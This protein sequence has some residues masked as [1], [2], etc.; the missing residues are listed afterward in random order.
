MAS[1]SPSAIGICFL[2][3]STESYQRMLKQLHHDGEKGKS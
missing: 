1:P 2:L 3:Y